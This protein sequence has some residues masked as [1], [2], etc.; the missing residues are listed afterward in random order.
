MYLVNMLAE[1][2]SRTLPLQSHAEGDRQTS[3]YE[4]KMPLNMLAVGQTLD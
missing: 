2:G 3:V 4:A 1:V